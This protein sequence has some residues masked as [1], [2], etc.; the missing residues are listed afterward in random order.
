MIIL[1]L[2]ADIL[3]VSCGTDKHALTK[4]VIKNN[5]YNVKTN[6]FGNAY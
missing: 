5:R 6:I 1:V 3:D 4:T 2:Q